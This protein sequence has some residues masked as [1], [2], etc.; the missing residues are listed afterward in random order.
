M[1]RIIRLLIVPLTALGS[2]LWTTP[3]SAQDIFSAIVE[4]DTKTVKKLLKDGADINAREPNFQLSPLAVAVVRNQPKVVRL[5]IKNGADVNETV[6]DG[7]TALHAAAF[8]GYDDIAK[9]LLKADADP[10]A[11][12]REGV[13][14]LSNLN[15]DWS[16]TEYL[17]SMLQ[18]PVE[19]ET[20]MAGREA[21]REMFEK[22]LWKRSKNDIWLAVTI[23]NDRAV[24]K[25]ARKEDNLDASHPEAPTTLI[26]TAAAMGHT[27]TVD[28]L[29]QAGADVNVRTEDG[30]TPLIAA[31]FFGRAETVQVLLDHGADKEIVSNQGMNALAAAKTDMAMVDY[32]AG[33]LNMDLDYDAVIEG[34]M[35]AIQILAGD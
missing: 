4:G 8:L 32:V 22:D 28:E 29:A 23:G 9:E 35:A 6:M 7:N 24:R 15:V 18:I 12:N 19:E 25:L 30:S 21:I 34:K 10:T 14:P 20:V 5:L 26:S 16:M 13:T 31:A 11:T 2:F 33:L 27:D 1:N 3:I 17:A